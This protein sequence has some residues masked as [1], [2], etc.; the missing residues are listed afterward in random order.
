MIFQPAGVRFHTSV[1]RPDESP[2]PAAV[3][4][5]AKRPGHQRDPVG[6]RAHVEFREGQRAH[7]LARRIALPVAGE[8]RLHAAAGDIA[9]DE[10]GLRRVVV[11]GCEGLQVAAIPRRLRVPHRF[12]D[13]RRLRQRNAGEYDTT[14][15]L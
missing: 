2:P 15:A 8:D 4:F 10:G 11:I 6:E 12:L 13:F 14:T 5:R 1:N 7:R 3:R 9:A